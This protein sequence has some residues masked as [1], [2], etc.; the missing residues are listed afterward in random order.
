[1]LRFGRRQNLQKVISEENYIKLERHFINRRTCKAKPLTSGVK[2]EARFGKQDFVYQPDTD[3]YRCPASETLTWCFSSLEHGLMLHGC[4]TSACRS[5]CAVEANC[6]AGIERRIERSEHEEV[7]EAMQVLDRWPDAMRVRR[8]TVE[9]THGTLNDWMGKDTS[10]H[11]GSGTSRPDPA[12]YPSLQHQ[13]RDRPAQCA[14]LDR[15]DAGLNNRPRSR[16]SDRRPEDVLTQP[17]A[18]SDITLAPNRGEGPPV[19]PPG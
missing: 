16:R 10:R 1:M 8:R 7:G 15:R 2:A 14:R 9:H 6:T 17:P 3:T 13:T 11:E 5:R 18:Q 4:A 19:S 12:S